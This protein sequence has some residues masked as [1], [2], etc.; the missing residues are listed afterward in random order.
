MQ[1][2]ILKFY[3]LSKAKVCDETT[4]L[5][6]NLAPQIR[7]WLSSDEFRQNY[8]H[9]TYAPLLN[10]KNI[11]YETSEPELCFILNI[12]L[13][14][15]F[16]FF[17]FGSHG[18]SLASAVPGFLKL[19]GCKC[20]ARDG[21]DEA[22]FMYISY[23]KRLVL[24]NKAKQNNECVSVA[25]LIADFIQDELSDKFYALV[26]RAK[27]LYIV[28]DPITNLK[29]LCNLEQQV[30]DTDAKDDDFSEISSEFDETIKTAK[31]KARKHLAYRFSADPYILS[32]D[33]IQYSLEVDG[34]L[35]IGASVPSADVAG[36]WMRELY[37]CFH[38]GML[39]NALINI[40]Q[41]DI[42]IKNVNGIKI[43]ILGYSYAYNGLED[44]L[45]DEDYE[46]HMSDLNEDKMKAEIQEAEKKA[47]VTIG[48]PQMGVE[49]QREPTQEQV[50][51]YHKMVD[52][53]AD[54]IF[55]GHPHVVEPSETVEKDGEKKFIIY[56]MGNF[57]SNQRLETVDDIWT[58]RG[59]LMDVTFEKKN[60]KTKIKTVAAHPTMVWVWS[61]GVTGSEGFV[62]SDYRTLILEDFIKGGKY[63]D[64]LDASMQ[65]K[66]DTA[67]QEM[68]ELV[69]LQWN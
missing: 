8:S 9:L 31:R 17:I 69:N 34:S 40:N 68:N 12:P 59:L 29:T 57:I 49:Y 13:P 60:H 5:F 26:P 43:A 14:P 32:K 53:G 24:A 27:T 2:E 20:V 19:C 48:M 38:D 30:G 3:E 56:S 62:L 45:S 55:G 1:D 18:V 6:I 10:P 61:K 51:L 11:N 47:D 41:E 16:D 7:A 25:L 35:N 39:F 44:N 4:Q 65:E 33:L 21:E 22:E 36:L 28:R 42:L 15:F 64:K 66:V 37:Q 54:V 50:T 58:E 23:F 63:R 46:K 67:Y 52:W